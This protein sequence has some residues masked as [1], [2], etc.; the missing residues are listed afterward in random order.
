MTGATT[1]GPILDE[2]TALVLSFLLRRLL[3]GAALIATLSVLAY[4]LLSAGSANVSQ[5]MLGSQASPEAL[6]ANDARLGLDEPV[7]TRLGDWAA[8]AVRGDL[9]VSWFTGQGVTDA[10]LSRLAVTLSLVVGAVL[11]TAVL[12][13]ALGVLAAVR[14]GW[15][16][17]T[18]QL[19]SVLGFA[20][21]SFLIALGLVI[22]FSLQ[23]G[24]LPATGYTRLSESPGEWAKSVVLPVTA[25][26]VSAV[27]GVAAQ[28]RGSM[29]EALRQDYVR[30]LR[31]RGLSERRVVLT[32]VLRN[33][34]GPSLQVLGLQFVALV[35]G[36]VLVEQ[37]FAIPGLGQVAVAATAQGDSPLIMGVV[38]VTGVIVVLV[39]LVVDLLQ[40]WLNPK[41][42][43]A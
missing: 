28:V 19:L 3:A 5:R 41:V 26:S 25:L 27:A 22:L 18:V 36:A 17:R 38:L 13:A 24:L 31:S 33:A 1:P 32:H 23:L 10:V 9:G 21:P 20:V 34:A 40:A 4:L 12:A 14:G 6:A 2:R 15:A 43:V 35:G 42:R 7:L 11:V 37:I 30:T 29:L 16:D 8:D 39:N